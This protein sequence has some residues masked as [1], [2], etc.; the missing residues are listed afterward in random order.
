MIKVLS[1]PRSLLV[2][3]LWCLCPV[4]TVWW[5]PAMKQLAT[6][7]QTSLL[8]ISTR[9]VM[10]AVA[11]AAVVATQ[12][13]AKM[14]RPWT[15]SLPEA[16]EVFRRW[17]GHVRMQILISIPMMTL[18]AGHSSKSGRFEKLQEYAFTYTFII[19]SLDMVPPL[20]SGQNWFSL[21]DGL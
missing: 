17:K 2:L 5:R 13:A 3:S 11:E 20:G 10:A 7:G 18:A 15:G 8:S 4:F 9:G 14:G 21:R 16:A 6:N 19:K 1:W 12:A